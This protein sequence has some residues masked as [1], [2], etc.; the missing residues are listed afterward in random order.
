MFRL[1]ALRC[2]ILSALLL[3]AFGFG[4]ESEGGE[5]PK[6]DYT[7]DI[8]DVGELGRLLESGETKEFERVLNDK[9][10]SIIDS[11][12]HLAFLYQVWSRNRTSYPTLA[13]REVDAPSVRVAI[14]DALLHA[15]RNDVADVP[16]A[17][18]RSELT[19][20]LD[21]RD[22]DVVR[23]ALSALSLLD[24][25]T[26][27]PA[28]EAIAKEQYPPTFRAAVIAMAFMCNAEAGRALDRLSAELAPENK[29][30]MEE[31]RARMTAFAKETGVCG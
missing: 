20:Y 11:L 30:I 14:A 3:V 10:A 6:L 16:I 26:D 24:D 8:A 23:H 25:E 15:V 19:S 27:V 21:A 7:P 4:V 1:R 31:I 2:L 17:E 28:I 22:N 9:K 12:N 29:S 13:W 18:I 5:L